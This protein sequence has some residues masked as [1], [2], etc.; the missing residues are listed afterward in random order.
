MAK[1]TRTPPANDGIQLIPLNHLKKS[2]RNVRKVPHTKAEIEELAASI[3]AHGLLQNP[4]VEPERDRSEKPTGY[5]LLTVGEGRRQALLLR[6]KR[7]EIPKTY[8]VRCLVDADHDPAEI[9]LAENAVRTPMHPADQFDAFHALHTE[10]GM[11]ADDIA[12][13]FGVSAAVVR[14]RLKLAAVSPKLIAAYRDGAMTLDQLSAFAIT[15]DVA[16]QERVWEESGRSASRADI[17]A[18]LTHA[19][20][21]ASD[22]RAVFVGADAYRAA[23]GALV[24]DLFDQEG[25]AYFA[26]AGLLMRLA[27]EKL[28]KLAE[29]VKAEG[30][31]WIDVLPRFDHGAVADCQR[32]YPAAKELSEAEQERLAALETECEAL[33]FD[34]SEESAAAIARIEEEAARIEGDRVF[35]PEIL[36]RAGAVVSIGSDGAPRIERGFVRPEDQVRPEKAAREK[37]A[38]GPSPL[39]EKLLTELTAFRTMALREALGNSPDTALTAVTHALALTACFRGAADMSCLLLTARGPNLTACLPAIEETAPARAVAARHAELARDLPEDPAQLW[40]YLAGQTADRR[41][42]LLA[43]CV[44]FTVDAVQRMP[45]SQER[46]RHADQLAFALDLDLAT[47]WRPTVQNYLGRVSKERILQAVR[48]GVSADAARNLT[49]LPKAAMAEAAET[50]LAAQRWLPEPLRIAPA[51]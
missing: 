2:P 28:E 44:A 46:T 22:P 40:D 29:G 32:V 48:E 35:A 37:P 11:A 7:K 15:D 21:P 41:L 47:A 26:D 34:G 31:K 20:L 30:W 43:H 33:E 17:L 51:P 13:R 14:Q 25:G 1:R 50:K 10:K 42:A 38:E 6:A 19:Q 3:K 24:Q 49:T 16:L 12:A 4:V 9:S 45:G 23:G 39:S 5:F 27:H 18:A 36:A 8:P